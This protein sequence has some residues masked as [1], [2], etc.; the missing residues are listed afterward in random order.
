MKELI[1]IDKPFGISSFD[2]IRKL[3]QKLGIKKMGYAGTLDP[4]ATG[5]LVVGV[6]QGTK[7][8]A[9]YIKLDKEYIAEILI[10]VRTESGDLDGRVLEEVEVDAAAETFSDEKVSA[11][12]QSLIGNIRL[13]VSAFSA[14]KKDGVPLYKKARAASRRG[15]SIPEIELPVREMKVYEAELLDIIDDTENQK[16]TIKARFKVG[17]GT[18]IRSLGE[19][20]GRRLVYPATLQGLRRTKVGEFKVEDAEVL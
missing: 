4:R 10:G 3:R 2:V 20:L 19:E 14:I 15:E 6:G 17:S 5:L 9:T 18:Y 12:L 16:V 1:L 7:A 11:A 13:P 8:L